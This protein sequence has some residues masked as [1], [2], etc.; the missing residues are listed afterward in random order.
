MQ[1]IL[2]TLLVQEQRLELQKVKQEQQVQAEQ[3]LKER[4]QLKEEP[5]KTMEAFFELCIRWYE[6]L[7]SKHPEW[8]LSDDYNA[9][10]FAQILEQ[11][12]LEQLKAGEPL[13]FRT[14]E[15][16][17]VLEL[18]LRYQALDRPREDAPKHILSLRDIPA[19]GW[20]EYLP[21][22]FRADRVFALGVMEDSFDYYVVNP[23][24]KHKEEALLF[25]ESMMKGLPAHLKARVLASADQPVES[26]EYLPQIERWEGMLAELDAAIAKA[27][28]LEKRELEQKRSQI[29]DSLDRF[30]VESRWE[31]SKED[32]DAFKAW[33]GAVCLPDFNPLPM[34]IKACPELFE[35]WRDNPAF[36]IDQFLSQLDQMSQTALKEDQ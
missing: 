22:T 7:N 31:I 2:E 17:R 16:K 10:S 32:I 23:Y 12:A 28:A 14:P 9:P 30:H 13:S 20:F 33:S 19:K 15:L 1:V 36:D 11:H 3:Q 24:S 4:Q 6:G 25:M 8:M 21:L 29:Q 27:P 35:S 18:F 5:P 34:L 26:A